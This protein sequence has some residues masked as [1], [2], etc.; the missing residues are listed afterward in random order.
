MCKSSIC[1]IFC[2]FL[3]L[4]IAKVP[5]RSGYGSGSG[6]NYPDPTK[7]VRIRN[8]ASAHTDWI[9][10]IYLAQYPRLPF[11]GFIYKPFII[12]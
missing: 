7:K 8:P 2:L 3:Q 12:L 4:Y 11:C 9:S 6:G 10:C 5:I 1:K